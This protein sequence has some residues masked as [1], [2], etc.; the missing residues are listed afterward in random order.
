MNTQRLN[1]T[2]PKNIMIQLEDKPNKSAFI[3]EAIAEK[4]ALD[5]KRRQERELAEAYR[6]SAAENRGLIADWDSL[7]GDGL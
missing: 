7:C 6:K 4:L 3:T 1:I 5:R 2:I